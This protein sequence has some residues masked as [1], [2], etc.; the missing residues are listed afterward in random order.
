MQ[1]MVI[2]S[3]V[4][5]TFLLF[6]YY[7]V[8]KGFTFYEESLCVVLCEV[9]AQNLLTMLTHSA[10]YPIHLDWFYTVHSDCAIYDLFARD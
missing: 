9:L 3:M 6:F 4:S 1:D 2:F 7:T 8:L 5:R 10:F